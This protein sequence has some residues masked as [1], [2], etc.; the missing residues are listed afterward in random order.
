[1]D[2]L[3]FPTSFVWI[4]GGLL[5]AKNQDKKENGSRERGIEEPDI[6]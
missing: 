1:M 3:G 2:F 4:L 6:W 5:D